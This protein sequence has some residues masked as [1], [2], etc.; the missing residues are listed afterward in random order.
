M[1][2]RSSCLRVSPSGGDGSESD[3]V[4]LQRNRLVECFVLEMASLG[5]LKEV[6]FMEV[7]EV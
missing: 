6:C 4:D 1:R 2:A 3:S 7:K 5:V